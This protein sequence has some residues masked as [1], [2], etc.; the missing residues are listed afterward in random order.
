LLRWSAD[1]TA[2]ASRCRRSIYDFTVPFR[3]LVS[4]CGALPPDSGIS[5]NE[6]ISIRV[7]VFLNRDGTLAAA[8]RL[9]ESN[10]SAKQQVLMQ[11]FVSGLQKCQPYT[12]LPQDRYKQWRMLPLVV[13]SRSYVSQ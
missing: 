2:V 12:M 13:Y 7:Q 5:P 10:P 4:S 11:G 9:L 6:N 1:G 8:P 3:E